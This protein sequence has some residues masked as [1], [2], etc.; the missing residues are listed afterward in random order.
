M[1][2]EKPW[3]FEAVLRLILGIV[4]TA[5]FGLALTG[6]VEILK[7]GWNED[8]RLFA[9]MIATAIFV[10]VSALVWTGFFLH[11]ENITWSRAFGFGGPGQWK[12]ILFGIMA[13][14][15]VLPAAMWLQDLS[16]K[17]MEMVRVHAE[18]QAV[19][20][21]L[22][23]PAA[24]RGETA[25]LGVFAIIVAPIAEE[26][27]F[28]GILYPSIKQAGH[29]RLALWFTSI[30]FGISHFSLVILVPLTVFALVLVLLYELTGNLIAPIVA[31]SLFN[32]SNFL[33][34]VFPHAAEKIWPFK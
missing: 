29:P 3:S 19:V 14:I 11:A 33:M 34:L 28:R 24:P 20:Q 23:K 4:A 6:L 22:Q 12:A 17:L 1:L 27:M 2:S 7:L 5:C 15:L 8:Q 32:A 21:A 16:A 31:H 18:P 26:T 10:Q 25:F 9:Q 30:L 13:A